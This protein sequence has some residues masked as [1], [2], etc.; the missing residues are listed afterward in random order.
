MATEW[1]ERGVGDFAAQG[2]DDPTLLLIGDPVPDWVRTPPELGGIQ[3]R[4]VR[5]FQAA[6]PHCSPAKPV[7]HLELESA[8][9]CGVAECREHGFTW[10]R[11]RV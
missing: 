4:V 6:C 1:F 11:R 3:L 8:E 5:G 2:M 10:Y 9:G 7:R